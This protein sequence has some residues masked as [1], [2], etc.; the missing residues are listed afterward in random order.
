M[1]FSPFAMAHPGHLG[2]HGF[3]SGLMHPL[4]GLDHLS[5]MVGV[6]ILAALFGG[7]SRW[8]MPIAFVMFMIIGGL[9]G[10]SGLVVPY[11]EYGIICSV[12][13]M[14]MLLLQGA[15][16]S[17]QW[18]T[19]LIMAFAIFHGMAHGAEMPLNSQALHYFAGFVLSTAMLHLV[20]IALGEC[21]LRLPASGRVTK[22]MGALMTLLGCSF[23]FS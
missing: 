6:G 22:M 15:T 9:L 3:E 4:S 23:L 21:A 8:L 18:V 16:M 13:I 2:S 19:G 12:I 20:G 10:L 17:Y 11:V 7:K 5:V 14:G 1:L